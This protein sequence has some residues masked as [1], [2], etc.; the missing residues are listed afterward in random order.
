MACELFVVPTEQVG[1][2]WPEI[3]RHISRIENVPWDLNDVLH[4]L[5]RA[6]A[7]A[8]GVRDGE[9][10]IG[11]V[12]TRI[13]NTH[14]HKYGLVWISAGTALHL[15]MPF[16]REVIEPWFWS[17]DCE[18]ID[19]CGRKGWKRVMPDYEEAAVILRKYR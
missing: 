17:H 9:Q 4:D 18:W 16:Y 19:L 10:V 8:W 7:Q 13:E 12:I 1:I 15:G 3:K 14:K 5:M 6:K 11:F 2:A